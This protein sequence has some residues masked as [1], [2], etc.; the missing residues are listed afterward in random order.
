MTT[1]IMQKAAAPLWKEGC[2]TFFSAASVS[3]TW[4]ML[5][6]STRIIPMRTYSH[7]GF[8]HAGSVKSSTPK[9]WTPGEE[10]SATPQ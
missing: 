9:A 1:A 3:H 10:I 5:Q 7:A 8:H 2:Q 4:A 6:A